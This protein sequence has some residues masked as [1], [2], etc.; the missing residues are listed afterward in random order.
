MNTLYKYICYLLK[1]NQNWIPFDR[2]LKIAL[3]TPKIG[4]YTKKN[5]R[6][7]DYITAPIMGHILGKC[8]AYHFI[9]ILENLSKDAIILEIGAKDITLA[10]AILS[11][12]EKKNRLPKEYWIL[13]INKYFREEQKK[14]LN[15]NF[16]N[17]KKRII[18][19]D[20]LPSYK[21]EG[22]ILGNEFLDSIPFKRFEI[23]QS[24]IFELG[25]SK[26]N[27]ENLFIWNR[28]IIKQKFWQKKIN[29]YFLPDGYRSEMHFLYYKYFKKLLFNLNEGYV[30]WIDYGYS[31]N[32][33]YHPERKDGTL[34]CYYKHKFH[35]NPF[36][37]IGNQDITS[38]V[39]FS[40]IASSLKKMKFIII[41][42]TTQ[43]NFL[44][45]NGL[46]NLQSKK[47]S[48]S[49]SCELK[50]LLLPNYMGDIF[51]FLGAYKGKKLQN[52]KS[53]NVKQLNL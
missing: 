32:I 12:L 14:I 26:K 18:W 17:F 21:F 3:Y 53:W 34:S 35:N 42:F 25:V 1:K 2:F 31:K 36:Q 6:N 9:P 43:T 47:I 39:N 37:Y 48:L 38:H 45:Q 8:I 28:S 40:E 52:L 5:I 13:E 30:L 22:I 51:K 16:P 33:Y 29:R 49:L 23:Y 19:I 27:K 7:K 24:N 11:L 41:G 15:T 50:K 44:L 10:I 20:K 46:M 4:Y